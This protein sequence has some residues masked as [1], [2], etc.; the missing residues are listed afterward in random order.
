L[1]D[2]RHKFFNYLVCGHVAVPKTV[3]LPQKGYPADIDL[4]LESL[5]NPDIP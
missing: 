3:V 1:V 2:G 4:A 5:H